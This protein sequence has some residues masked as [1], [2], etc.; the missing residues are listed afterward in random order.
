MADAKP[1][2]KKPTK[3]KSRSALL[4]RKLGHT[5]GDVERHTPGFITFDFLGFAD[6]LSIVPGESGVT[7]YQVTH[8]DRAAD[9][10]AAMLANA[11][12]PLWLRCGNRIRLHLWDKRGPRGGLK[13]WTLFEQK[14]RLDGDK[15]D[16][17]PRAEIF[18]GRAPLPTVEYP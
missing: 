18:T 4:L 9:H 6:L 8:C 10:V 5:V 3:L 14:F 13:R 16:L 11:N 7:A 12:V 17:D 2:R 1:K 15:L